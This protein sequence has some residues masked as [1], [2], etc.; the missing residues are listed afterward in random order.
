MTPESRGRSAG[1]STSARRRH[2]GR[3][4]FAI[5]G[6]VTWEDDERGEVS[7]FGK[8][9]DPQAISGMRARML[10]LT[11]LPV[12]RSIRVR[13]GEVAEMRMRTQLFALALGGVLF[14][15]QASLAAAARTR[16]SETIE[17]R[18]SSS[19]FIADANAFNGQKME[20]TAFYK[21]TGIV[22]RIFDGETDA[23]LYD[24]SA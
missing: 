18:C 6:G 7:G 24:P 9:V 3:Q 10:G 21:A 15:T 19:G 23:L 13:N 16:H 20:V 8:A 5:I 2:S 4:E 11:P 22:C 14:T 17:V 12:T 1:L